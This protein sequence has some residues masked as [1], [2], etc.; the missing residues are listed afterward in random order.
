ME[1]LK[2][3]PS[4][5]IKRKLEVGVVI[6]WSVIT[7]IMIVNNFH[8]FYLQNPFTM[9]AYLSP[10]FTIIERVI[11]AIISLVATIIISDVKRVVYGFFTS[12]ILIFIIGILSLFIYIWSVFQLGLVFQDIPF[13]WETALF[14]A[15]IK[16]VGFMIPIGFI[17]SL[18]GV[19]VGT[20]VSFLYKYA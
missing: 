5:L 15:L 11:I 4:I 3:F 2:N 1:K 6:I 10:A 14:T 18:I 20:V 13:G 16:V 9:S 8:S 19:V 17:F 7:S 12:T